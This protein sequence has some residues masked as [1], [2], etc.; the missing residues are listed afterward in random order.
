MLTK[1]QALKILNEDKEYEEKIF[2]GLA[3]ASVAKL[4]GGGLEKGKLDEIVGII[5]RMMKDT[6]EHEN[7]L[8]Y[9][10]K[11]VEVSEKN[12]F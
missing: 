7:I 3:R 9:L 8:N 11:Y 4:R 6:A 5:K 2:R 10:I 12:G 1:V